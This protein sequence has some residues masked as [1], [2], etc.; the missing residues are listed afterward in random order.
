MLQFIGLNFSGR[1]ACTTVV[2]QKA[3]L[4]QEAS[5]PI[6]GITPLPRPGIY[7]VPPQ[8]WIRAGGLA[9]RDAYFSLPVKIR[10]LWGV[11][12]A[13]PQGWIGI[14]PDLDPATPLRLTPGVSPIADLR[15]WLE[16][17]PREKRR[18]FALLSPKDYFRF[19]VSGALAA[20]LT[21]ASQTGLLLKGKSFWSAAALNEN[22]LPAHWFPPVFDCAAITG[23]LNEAGM[24]ITGIPEGFWLAAGADTLAASEFSANAAAGRQLYVLLGEKEAHLRF[25]IPQESDAS[26]LGGWELIQHA[27]GERLSLS[28]EVQVHPGEARDEGPLLAQVEGALAALRRAGL[29]PSG[30][31]LDFRAGAPPWLEAFRRRS[32]LQAALGTF[33][34]R[35]DPGPAFFAGLAKRSFRD[36]GD[37]FLKIQRSHH[38]V[39][40]RSPEEAAP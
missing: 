17:H 35:Q 38:E 15:A 32:P 10:R 11:A 4:I 21:Q 29:A 1:S 39:E 24:E 13:G 14:D 22:E 40:P 3:R 37:L 12:L 27:G 5:V 28:R 26:P 36:P 9:L 30:L 20:D 16:E 8:E 31:I 23:R 2:D 7:E 19:R 6:Q 18:L 33:A 25:A 34:G